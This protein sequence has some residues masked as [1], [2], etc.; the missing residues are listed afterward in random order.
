MRVI[1][2]QLSG[3]NC[4]TAISVLRH[5]D[6]SL[7]P[8]GGKRK[9]QGLQEG[10]GREGWK[11]KEARKKQGNPTQEKR[12]Y[13]RPAPRRG[14]PGSSGPAPRKSPERAWRGLCPSPHASPGPLAFR[15]PTRPGDPLLGFSIRNPPPLPPTLPVPRTP[16]SPPPTR[17]NIENIRNAHKKQG[18]SENERKAK[19]QGLEEGQPSRKKFKVSETYTGN[20]KKKKKKKKQERKK[21]GLEDGSGCFP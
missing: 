2:R 18:Q 3:K 6:A 15:P 9:R 5:Q 16:P 17:K 7:G 21:Q 13:D 8:L 14:L 10:Q 19:K 20:R 12:G 11:V 1:A 4:L